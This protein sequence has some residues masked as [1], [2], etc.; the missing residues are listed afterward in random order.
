MFGSSRLHDDDYDIMR[1]IPRT[2]EEGH[3]LSTRTES[4]LLWMSGSSE[5]ARTDC[6]ELY[7]HQAW[8]T[9]HIQ[10]RRSV[11]SPFPRRGNDLYPRPTDQNLRRE[12]I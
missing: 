12:I 11:C 4:T 10:G 6:I 5:S 8:I 7:M 2:S 1:Y 9:E 3:Q